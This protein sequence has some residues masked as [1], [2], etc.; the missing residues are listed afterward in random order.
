MSKRGFSALLLWWCIAILPGWSLDLGFDPGAGA[1]GKVLSLAVQADDSVLVGGEFTEFNGVPRRGIARLNPNGGLDLSFAPSGLSNVSAIAIQ[2]DGRILLGSALLAPG[3]PALVRVNANGTVDESF[4]PVFDGPVH[5]IA[6]SDNGE[7]WVGG[8][9][10]QVNGLHRGRIVRLNE[11]GAVDETFNPGEGLND[12]VL[13][14]LSVGNGDVLVGGKFYSVSGTN[15]GALVRLKSDGTVDHSFRPRVGLD[16]FTSQFLNGQ[17]VRSLAIQS[18]G[19]VVVGGDIVTRDPIVSTKSYYGLKRVLTDGQMDLTFTASTEAQGLGG[20]HAVLVEPNDRIVVAGRFLSFGGRSRSYLLRLDPTGNL[21]D[22]FIASSN[23]APDRAVYALAKQSGDRI[24]AAGEFTAIGTVPRAAVAGFLGGEPPLVPPTVEIVPVFGWPR[25]AVSGATRFDATVS[26]CHGRLSLQWFRDGKALVGGTGISIQVGHSDATTAGNYS[27]VASN[28]AGMAT[29]SVFRVDVGMQNFE[30]NT[31]NGPT[32]WSETPTLSGVLSVLPLRN[33]QVLIGGQFER[34]E[35]EPWAHLARLN[36]DGTLDRTFTARPSRPVRAMLE[37][38]DGR[39]VIAGEFNSVNG[40]FRDRVARLEPDGSLD[41]NFAVRLGLNGAMHALGMQ[42]D[43]K[44]IAGGAFHIARENQPWIHNLVRLQT[45]GAVD[46]T[47]D[48][49]TN[50]FATNISVH[51]VRAV[52]VLPDGKIMAGGSFSRAARSGRDYLAR[53]LPNGSL[54]PDFGVEPWRGPSGPIYAMAG[55]SDGILV[56]GGSFTNVH[57][58]AR[59]NL[60]RL[61]PDGSVDEAFFPTV[62]ANGFI[63]ALTH[64]AGGRVLA[65]RSTIY[66]DGNYNN[67]QVFR[68]D[69]MGRA[70]SNQVYGLVMRNGNPAGIATIA[71]GPAG[72][73]FIG[74]NFDTIDGVVRRR[75]ALLLGDLPGPPA[76]TAAPVSQAIEETQ[77]LLLTA[78]VSLSSETS[79]QWFHAGEGVV[80]T[81][82]VFLVVHKT[83]LSD[84]GNYWLVASNQFGAATSAVATAT[85]LAAGRPGSVD[86]SFV[87]WPGADSNVLALAEAPDGRVFVG[88][89]FTRFHGSNAMELVRL[90]SSGSLDTGFARQPGNDGNISAI[91]T[92]SDGSVVVAQGST[93]RRYLFDGAVDLAWQFPFLLFAPLP[94]Q[95][96][97]P[98]VNIEEV[99]DGRMVAAG[100]FSLVYQG[101]VR[102]HHDLRYALRLFADGRLDTSFKLRLGPRGFYSRDAVIA[103]DIDPDENPIIA[104]DPWLNPPMG[105]PPVFRLGTYAQDDGS[106]NNRLEGPTWVVTLLVQSDGRM[107]VA[108]DLARL[109]PDGRR[110]ESFVPW[111]GGGEIQ[112]VL[113]LQPGGKVLVTAASTNINGVNRNRIVRLNSD[114]SLDPSFDIGTGPNGYVSRALVRRDGKILVSGQFNTFGGFRCGNIALLHGGPSEEPSITSQLQTIGV[115]AGGA[116]TLGPIF[117]G[118]PPPSIQWFR[119]GMLLVGATQAVLRLPSSQ[120]ADSGTYS[121]VQS[122]GQGVSTNIVAVVAVEASPVQSGVVDSG[123]LSGAGP[124]DEVQ[125]IDVQRD[126]RILIGGTFRSIDGM[127]RMLVARLLDNGSLDASFNPNGSFANSSSND[128]RISRIISQPDGKVL[129][130]GNFFLPNESVARSLA[131]LNADGTLDTEFAPQSHGLLA[132]QPDGKILAGHWDIRRLMPDGNLDPGFQPGTGANDQIRTACLQSDGKIIIIGD[133]ISFNGIVRHYVARLNPDGSLDPSFDTAD[134]IQGGQNGDVCFPSNSGGGAGNGP[135]HL[136]VAVQSD[137]RILVGGAFAGSGFSSR[138]NLMRLTPSGVVD[139]E[140][141]PVFPNFAVRAL[142]VQSDGKILIGGCFTNVSDGLTNVGR[143]HIARL[144]GD[145][146]IDASFNPGAGFIG[147]SGGYV[148]AVAVQPDGRVLLGGQFDAVAGVRRNNFARLTGDLIL[149]ET[150][151]QGSGFATHVATTAGRTYWLET[152]QTIGPGDW[153]VVDTAAG[154]GSSQQLKD[155]TPGSEDRF[156]R[157]RVE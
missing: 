123:F 100:S 102:V 12:A 46:F 132:L 82:N 47:F 38:P 78:S 29:S 151:V 109:W 41:T 120:I 70:L 111:T 125:A 37:Q 157:V 155:E 154:D 107:L 26:S 36:P 8:D 95:P 101:N 40:Q 90:H 133:F 150:S 80:G 10:T 141:R 110:D 65:V 84:A 140:F 56:I 17:Q 130:A 4:T 85:V 126:G 1:N 145:G 105:T 86:T 143:Y 2:G 97:P 108:P 9:F 64:D 7:V 144:N 96:I 124:D 139:P 24:L 87:S 89:K 53:L 25:A 54:D 137:G 134:L 5:A 3:G 116:V 117:A 51:F 127:P 122:N 104:F 83:A 136:A 39:I 93:I 16:P 21:D 28:T 149:F 72:Q 147:L 128:L 57:G 67:S 138:W 48:P 32:L 42:P 63:N 59:T 27:V 92:R 23:A 129:I 81:T 118:Y 135:L 114:G 13:T 49:G 45:N 15:L 112:A 91:L 73:F 58:V 22:C 153:I 156:Y 19:K 94:F 113:A 77:D 14:L 6:I 43:G 103:L 61:M 11:T 148:R 121:L 60:A 55:M 76:F 152:R 50:L 52:S 131:R 31:T 20:V 74:G 71:A 66:L 119:N 33:G 68:Y 35:L 98:I 88:G 44:V 69:A 62:S 34:V 75:V 30:F 142:A 115:V 146:S 106:I 18:D 79:F 99:G